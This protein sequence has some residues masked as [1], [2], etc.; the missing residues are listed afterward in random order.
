MYHEPIGKVLSEDLAWFL[1]KAG[2]KVFHWDSDERKANEKK[3][4]SICQSHMGE[5]VKLVG[6]LIDPNGAG[7]L[8]AIMMVGMLLVN[9]AKLSEEEQAKVRRASRRS[10][11]AW[12]SPPQRRLRSRTSRRRPDPL[13]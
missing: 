1:A 12:V 9:H 11:R 10:G 2:Q 8:Q 3:F 4:E 7:Q 6:L 13:R 5:V